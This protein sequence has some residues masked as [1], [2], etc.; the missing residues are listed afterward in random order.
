MLP[1]VIWNWAQIKGIRLVGTGDFT[2]PLWFRGLTRVL[3]PV[4]NGIFRLRESFHDDGVP[5][6]CASETFFMLS[7]EISC[8]YRKAEKTRKIHCLVYV[9]DFESALRI[10][11]VL[12]KIGNVKSDGR[13]ILGLDAKELLRITLNECPSAIFIPAHVWTPHFSVFGGVYGFDSLEECFEELTPHIR[14]IETG[15]S[16]NP[17]M[18][19][20]IS[21][22]DHLALI[23][24]SDAHSPSKLGRE[25]TIFECDLSYDGVRSAI[26]TGKGIAGT[27]EFF[28]EE[29][30]YHYDGH[31]SCH[32]RLSPE[33]TFMKNKICPVCGKMVTAGVLSRVEELSDR[34]R[35]IPYPSWSP[36]FH[37]LIPLTEI[38]GEVMDMGPGCKR[39]NTLYRR[40][41]EE[42]GNE[43]SVLIEAPLADIES[44]ASSAVREAISRVRTGDVCI[45]PG[46][47]GQ[48]GSIRI[49]TDK[50]RQKWRQ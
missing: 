5:A 20:H 34:G 31:R 9:P 42:M 28:P 16:S 15:L 49:F 48:F 4:G 29:G 25:A 32:V 36:P 35:D 12:S 27:I 37:S 41:L 1:A 39:V 24:N 22:L 33:D 44:A 43:L 3:E 30:K 13:P 23:S 21:N 40:I 18:N 47:D 19:R 10:S 7:A 26:E 14:A 6:S 2:H 11:N 17:L 45:T 38:I 50:E 8:I 46:Y